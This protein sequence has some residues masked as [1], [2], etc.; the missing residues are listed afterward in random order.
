MHIFCPS[1]ELRII[2][3]ITCERG[4]YF[5]IAGNC[6]NC[7]RIRFT[8]SSPQPLFLRRAHQVENG[9]GGG[10]K[11]T[12]REN[13]KHKIRRRRVFG[14]RVTSSGWLKV[15]VNSLSTALCFLRMS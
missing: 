8:I 15:G 13:K 2:F 1:L 4:K 12:D 11:V 5:Y 3:R 7:V 14:K 9:G 10:L 6:G